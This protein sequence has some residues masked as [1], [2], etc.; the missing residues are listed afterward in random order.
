MSS[1][2]F[3]TA[4]QIVGTFYID[5][6]DISKITTTSSG[7]NYSSSSAT[8]DVTDGT[9]IAK[10]ETA[11][12]YLPVAPFVA[13]AGS[14]LTVVVAASSQAGTGAHEK[15]ITL[16]NAVEFKSGKIKTVKVN[17]TTPFATSGGGNEGDV[18]T[19]VTHDFTKIS[20]TG[21]SNS[22]AQHA[23]EYDLSTVTFAAASKQ[24]GTITNMPVTKGQP[25]SIVAK[26]AAT[27]KSAKF[28]CK[29]WTTKSQTITLK[30][31]TDGGKTFS[32]TG[33][34]STNFTISKDNLP[35]GTDAVQIT[36]SSTSNQVGI[37]S[38]TITYVTNEAEAAAPRLSVTP[39]N[40]EFAASGGSKDVSCTI[41]NEVSGVELTATPSAS[42]VSASV[43]G[44]TITITA[45]ENTASED[46]TATVTIAYEG[47]ESETVTVNQAGATASGGE[48]IT[49]EF[50]TITNKCSSYTTTWKQTCG[51]YTWSIVNFN[52]NNAGWKFIKCGRKGNAS[53]ASINT[54]FSIPWAVSNVTVT[55]DAVT[56][57]KVNSTYLQV[58]TDANFTNIVEKVSVSIK[59]GSVVYNIS[60]PGA[61]YYY[62][63]VYDCASGSSNGLVQIS[64]VVY[65]AQ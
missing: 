25:V 22:Y 10:G 54:S 35:E 6:T 24:T 39:W 53:V 55:V 21:W 19:T 14:N 60:N 33:V 40:V 4:E 15:T 56:T 26:N 36:F 12:F 59:T 1:I 2:Q 52:N 42:W 47:A 58:A 28:V 63:L 5:F 18:E 29:Q 44:K 13:K 3:T 32:S 41:E 62:K 27:I 30:Y 61:N 43:N 48:D 8:L 51:N 46:R 31:S 50:S 17:Y 11:K 16:S 38:A 34:T 45:D 37:E 20:F 57:S 64:K 23:V 49:L 65:T 9:A 7:A